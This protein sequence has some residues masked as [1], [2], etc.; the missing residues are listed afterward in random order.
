MHPASIP[1]IK[2]DLSA[3]YLS[4]LCMQAAT[5][6]GFLEMPKGQRARAQRYA[7]RDSLLPARSARCPLPTCLC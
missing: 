2:P 6:A 7:I 5:L 1:Q 3:N 4:L